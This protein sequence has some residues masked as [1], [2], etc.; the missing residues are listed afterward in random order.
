MNRPIPYVRIER[1][2][3]GGPAR[4]LIAKGSTRNQKNRNGRERS[5]ETINREQNPCGSISVDAKKLEHTRHQIRIKRRLPCGG[6]GIA[7]I[8]IAETL[9]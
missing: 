1:P 9:S 2:S 8:R 5:E 6:A 3:P 7:S 4:H